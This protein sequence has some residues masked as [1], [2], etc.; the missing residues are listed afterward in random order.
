MKSCDRITSSDK[1]HKQKVFQD[2][3]EF[4]DESSSQSSDID[5]ESMYVMYFCYKH[6]SADLSQVSNRSIAADE[7]SNRSIAADRPDCY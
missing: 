1:T 3:V 4:R 7:V 2:D 5:T 6:F